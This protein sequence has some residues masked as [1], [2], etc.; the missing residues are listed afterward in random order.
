MTRILAPLAI[1]AATLFFATASA[2]AEESSPPIP[3]PAVGAAPTPPPAEDFD[4]GLVIFLFA[5]RI[6]AVGIVPG[7]P[8]EVLVCYQNR[9]AARGNEAAH[10]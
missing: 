9:H 10:E 8:P 2:L 6:V 4:G 5:M 3:A 7:F 1:L